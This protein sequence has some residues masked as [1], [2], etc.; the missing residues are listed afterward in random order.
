MSTLREKLESEV[1]ACNWV[2]IAAFLS[3]AE[4]LMLDASLSIVDVGLA[5]AEDSVVE[6]KGWL[7]KKKIVK[8]D[9]D[10]PDNFPEHDRDESF[11]LLVVTPFALAQKV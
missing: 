11:K 5:F 1:I 4:V 10:D 9:P 2:D 7:D 8:I 3:K 6:V